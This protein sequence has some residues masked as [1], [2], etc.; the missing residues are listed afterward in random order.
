MSVEFPI[1]SGG[2]VDTG[3]WKAH[4]GV[5]LT[6]Y[7]TS[8]KIAILVRSDM[9][10]AC[11]I[12][13][14]SGQYRAT[15]I[16]KSG[17]N[18]VVDTN[19]NTQFVFDYK[20]VDLPTPF[21][22]ITG[23]VNGYTTFVI[24]LEL[25]TGGATCAS[26]ITTSYGVSAQAFGHLWAVINLTCGNS[27]MFSTSTGNQSRYFECAQFLQGSITTYSFYFCTSLIKVAG[28]THTTNTNYQNNFTSCQSLK[29]IDFDKN[30][31]SY[32]DCFSG[33]YNL[34]N[35]IS[36]TYPNA[37][38]MSGFVKDN[39]KRTSIDITATG[40][41]D[42]RNNANLQSCKSFYLRSTNFKATTFAT[43]IFIQN[44]GNMSD[45]AWAN[46]FNVLEDLTGYTGRTIDI[47]GSTLPSA[48]TIA[49]ATA[50]NWTIKT[51]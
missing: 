5:D 26:F 15:I 37:T 9:Y 46:W 11:T 31:T 13:T 4:W 6:T 16:G 41:V 39:Y 30:G 22:D 45:T 42:F 23:S 32:Q 44:M 40:L 47:A 27:Y 25:L 34:N 7:A 10:Y 17:S 50:K 12:N 2:G 43:P 21:D 29:E 19:D 18:K 1:L 38:A 24:T 49:I 20:A 3:L 33:C 48:S 28:F 14:S 8:G 51:A 36:G 35:D